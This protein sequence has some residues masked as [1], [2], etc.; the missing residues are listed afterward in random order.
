MSADFEKGWFLAYKIILY[1]F[2]VY[3]AVYVLLGILA[4]TAATA[5]TGIYLLAVLEPLIVLVLVVFE[6]LA[7]KNKDAKKAK[8]ALYGFIGYAIVLLFCI[9]LLLVGDYNP[10]FS[11]AMISLFFRNLVLLLVFIVYG[12]VQVNKV[13]GG[14][15]SETSNIYQTYNTA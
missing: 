5:N 8:T 13:L 15:G 1:L 9:F 2:G 14:S 4:L 6:I 11:S 12:A 10:N 3:E 7:M